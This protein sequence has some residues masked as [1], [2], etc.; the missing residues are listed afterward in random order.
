M[1]ECRPYRRRWMKNRIEKGKGRPKVEEA[2]TGDIQSI[3]RETRGERRELIEE[4]KCNGGEMKKKVKAIE[5][6]MQKNTMQQ[7]VKKG[8]KKGVK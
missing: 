5:R 3:E 7:E 2:N 4:D 6:S 1:T 8:V